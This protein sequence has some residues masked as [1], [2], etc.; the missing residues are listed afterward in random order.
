MIH[1]I[2]IPI[3]SGIFY[4][5]SPE[6]EKGHIR[7]ETQHKV[8]LTQGFEMA[9]TPVTQQQWQAVM[10]ENPSKFKQFS[11]APVE[12]INWHDAMR[13]CEKLTADDE[14]G[15]HYQLPTEAQWEYACRAGT[16]G[17]YNVAKTT[18]NELG[19]YDGNSE[20][21]T[22]SVKQKRPNGFGLYDMH[23][24][25]WEWCSDWYV[26][27]LGCQSVTD[28]QGP[29]SGAGRVIRGG[30]WYYD[31]YCCRSACRLRLDLGLRIA[32]VGFRPVRKK[33]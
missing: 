14:E 27:V 3:P 5:G 24:N 7:N 13:Y 12:N 4:M 22:H 26:S 16:Q 17:P 33:N 31:E 2:F 6:N 1:P 21:A 19:W 28:P 29:E 11:D 32:R 30:C 23:G 15:W 10:G 25:V 8:R 9:E 20:G 18:L